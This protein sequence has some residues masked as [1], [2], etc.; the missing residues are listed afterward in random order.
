MSL[1]LLFGV[2]VGGTRKGL[3]M[4]ALD[5]I[6]RAI[7]AVEPCE[8]PEHL[9][10]TIQILEPNPGVIAIDAPRKATR[11]TTETRP[12][13]RAIHQMGYRIQWTRK[14]LPPEWMVNGETVWDAIAAEFPDARLVETFPTAVSGRLGE[15]GVHL[16]LEALEGA[17][18]RSHYKDLLDA[19]LCAAVALAVS[20]GKAIEVGSNDPLGAIY[21]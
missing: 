4:A 11:T 19:C 1:G 3:H 9:V 8:N 21:I 17:M 6:T 2:D 18:L 13:E 12:A 10:E 14:T 5:P 16:P 20:E 15:L 7:V